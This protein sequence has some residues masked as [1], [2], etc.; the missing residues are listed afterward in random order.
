MSECMV[1]TW[2]MWRVDGFQMYFEVARNAAVHRASR[3]FR[4]DFRPMTDIRDRTMQHV[5]R[6]FSALLPGGLT[7]V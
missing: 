3:Y 2:A 6:F 1:L 5:P 7:L 4:Y